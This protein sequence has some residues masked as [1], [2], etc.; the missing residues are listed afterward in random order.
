MRA[1]ALVLEGCGTLKV[2]GGRLLSSWIVAALFGFSEL[3]QLSQLSRRCLS[4]RCAV[5]RL[6]LVASFGLKQV[7]I[8]S[9][10][11]NHLAILQ[12]SY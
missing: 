8:R 2:E 1:G 11:N 6:L 10:T 4:F 9:P 3:D 7:F 5:V 12:V